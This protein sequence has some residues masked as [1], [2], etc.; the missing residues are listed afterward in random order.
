MTRTRPFSSVSNTSAVCPTH[1]K[2]D[3]RVA[4]LPLERVDCQVAFLFDASV[5]EET[6]VQHAFSGH[7]TGHGHEKDR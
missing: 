1:S 3:A 2:A 6:C 5:L 7:E 4:P